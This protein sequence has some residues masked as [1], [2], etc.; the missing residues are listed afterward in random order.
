MAVACLPTILILLGY[1]AAAFAETGIADV[2]TRHQYLSASLAHGLL[3]MP[4]LG[5]GYA[6]IALTM[7]V[8]T[9]VEYG[10]VVAVVPAYQ[11]SSFLMNEKNPLPPLL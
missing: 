10:M 7:V 4:V 6:L 5:F 8:G 3:Y 2:L 11:S 1:A 9:H